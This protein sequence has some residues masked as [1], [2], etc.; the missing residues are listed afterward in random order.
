[1]Q[2]Y[3]PLLTC[4]QLSLDNFWSSRE[5]YSRKYTVM[6]E[7]ERGAKGEQERR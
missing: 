7:E 5:K 1:M 3:F 4:L 6:R 2:S